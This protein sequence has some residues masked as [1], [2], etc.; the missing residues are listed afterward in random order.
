MFV[1][2]REC[3]LL[4]E[5]PTRHPSAGDLSPQRLGQLLGQHR[6]SGHLGV[7]QVMPLEQLD[8]CCPGGSCPRPG[9]SSSTA[10]PLECRNWPMEPRRQAALTSRLASRRHCSRRPQRGPISSRAGGKDSLIAAIVS[11]RK[12]T[13]MVFPV[14]RRTRMR[15]PSPEIDA[16]R[17]AAEIT[18]A[19]AR[20]PSGHDV[21]ASVRLLLAPFW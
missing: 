3:V 7:V 8:G 16:G 15:W 19:Q 10:V 20:I 11:C 6:V 4:S 12:I 21:G 5:V 17:T 1:P 9:C 2:R 14:L 13:R 18:A